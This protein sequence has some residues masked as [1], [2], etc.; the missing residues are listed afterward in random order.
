MEKGAIEKTELEKA[1]EL[2][3]NEEKAKAEKC[4]E[5]YN[6]ALKQVD[7]MGFQF[8]SAGEFVGNKLSTKMV[9]VKK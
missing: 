2:V 4:I 3:A 1:K 7:E 8:V 6:A 9:L 5:I